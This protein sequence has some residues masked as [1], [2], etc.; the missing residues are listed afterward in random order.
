MESVKT[1]IQDAELKVEDIHEVVMVGGS[2]RI[3]KVQELIR[4]FMK[5]DKLNKQVNP[6]EAV[7]IGATI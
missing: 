5:C 2:S 1:A 7:A 4:D 6:D 3:P